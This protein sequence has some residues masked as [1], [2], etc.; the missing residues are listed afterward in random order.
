MKYLTKNAVCDKC[1]VKKSEFKIESHLKYY[2][3]TTN[4]SL[5][6]YSDQLVEAMH[7]EADTMLSKSGYKV[8]DFDSE[9]CGEKLLSF[10]KH[11]NSYNL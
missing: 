7:S 11:F 9:V 1:G 4:K 8:N 6:Y 3:K 2:F 10:I 5:G